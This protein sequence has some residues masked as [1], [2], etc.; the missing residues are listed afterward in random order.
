MATLVAI[1]YPD[2]GTAEQ[3]RN[4]VRELESDLV[5]QAE[6]VASIS[7]DLEGKYHVQTSHGGASAGGGAWWGGFW[8]FLFGLLFFIPF[9]GLALGAGMGAL[10]GHFGQKGIDKAFQEQV[11][12]YLKPGTSALFMVI[13]QVT[14]DKAIAAL[15]QYGGTVIR[16]SLSD[17][18]TK[19]L[20]EALQPPAPVS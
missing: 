12:D 20:E 13:D 16:T 8:G 1:G 15:Q 7:R 11:R 17:E 6:Q 10:F 2:Q 5:I 3:A 9:A 14:P 18:D 4:T 19:K